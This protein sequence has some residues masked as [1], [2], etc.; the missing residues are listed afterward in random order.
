MDNPI[1]ITYTE[2]WW[3]SHY[4]AELDRSEIANLSQKRFGCERLNA[5]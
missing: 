1:Y 4:G 5:N 3:R 2:I